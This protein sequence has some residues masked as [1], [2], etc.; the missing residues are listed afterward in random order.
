MGYRGDAAVGLQ[1]QIGELPEQTAVPWFLEK[2]KRT[3]SIC[4]ISPLMVF[5]FCPRTVWQPWYS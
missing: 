1:L 4:L 5:E 2:Q 3:V